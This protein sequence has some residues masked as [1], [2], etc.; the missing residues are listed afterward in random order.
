VAELTP[1]NEVLRMMAE[2]DF[3]QI[4]VLR[5]GNLVG[6]ITRSGLVRYLQYRQELGVDA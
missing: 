1:V 4:P 6:L 2:H 3:H 5:D